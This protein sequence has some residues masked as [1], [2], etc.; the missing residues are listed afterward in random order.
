MKE[1]LRGQVLEQVLSNV[2][3]LAGSAGME[4]RNLL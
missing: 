2:T 1:Q 3:V 4:E